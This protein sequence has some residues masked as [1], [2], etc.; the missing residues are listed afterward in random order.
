[1]DQ[2]VGMGNM[3]ENVRKANVVVV[4]PTHIAVR[5]TTKPA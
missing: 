1:M 5:C 2:E 3:L 4:N